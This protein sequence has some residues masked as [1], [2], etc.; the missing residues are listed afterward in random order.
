M[1]AGAGRD[2]QRLFQLR[3]GD[4]VHIL[5]IDDAVEQSTLRADGD[6]V[7]LH[8]LAA[9][10]HRG[11]QCQPKALALAQRVTHRTV[12]GAHHLAALVQKI[13]GGVVLAGKALHKA[14]IVAVGH[15]AD[16]LAVVFA[17]IDE[18]ML[19]GDGTHLGLVQG[20]QRQ[21][22]MS[23]L[24]LGEVVQHIALI[25]ALIQPL[26]EQPA[27]GV[28]VLF[29]PGIVAGDY[30]FHAVG[31]RPVQQMVELHVFITI[32]AGVWG[33]ASLI[34]P[35][36]LLDDLFP[37]VGGEVQ[38]LVRDIQGK[39]HLGG[40]LDVLFR[41]AGVETGLPQHLVVGQAHGDAGAV[42][43]VPLH[44]PSSHRAVHAAAHGNEGV[45][46]PGRRVLCGHSF[47]FGVFNTLK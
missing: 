25:L 34:H 29:H 30:I 9:D 47:S 4:P 26:F 15:K 14:G 10:V 27:A 46:G 23:Q 20:P 21:A 16:V 33:A 11:P 22:H 3:D 45:R 36:K 32:N 39:G 40:V 31:L 35:D 44:Q 43:P 7:G 19:L 1:V 2:P 37:E 6:R 18:M 41:A 13:T 42:V 38:H 8:V 28:R 24:L 12:V 17:G 5:R